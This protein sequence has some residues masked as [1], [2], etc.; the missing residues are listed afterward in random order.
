MQPERAFNWK[1]A[2]IYQIY[3]RSFQDS[4]GDGV[5]DIPGIIMR[6]DYIASL[7]VDAVWLNPIYASPNA[8]NGYD[9]SDYYSVMPEF[10]DLADFDELVSG[11]HERGLHLIMDLVVNH[12]SDEHH[13][14]KESRKSADNFYADFYHWWPAARGKPPHRWSFFSES[15]A[16]WTYVP[17]RDAWYL[18]YFGAKQPDLNWENPAVR[19]EVHRLMRFWLDRG[20]DGFRLD[21]IPFIAKDTSFPELPPGSTDE[22]FIAHYV[23]GPNLHQYLQELQRE[24]LSPYGAMSVGEAPGVSCGRAL[25]FVAR[26]R[27]EL[28]MFFHFDL[29]SI[30]RDPGNF[31]RRRREG[32]ALA[33]LRDIFLRWDYVFEND[34]WTAVYLGNHDFPRA[35]SRWTADDKDNWYRAATMLN[36]LL[37][38]IR[39]TP[40]LYYGDEIGMRNIRFQQI[41]E[42]RDGSSISR[43]RQVVARGGEPGEFL[44]ELAETSRDNARTPMQ[45]DA[46]EHAG[47][48]TSEP[49]ISVNPDHADWVSVAAQT[50]RE[51]SVLTFVRQLISYRRRSPALLRGSMVPVHV[52]DNAY[53]IYYRKAP[54]EEILVVLNFSIDRRPLPCVAEFASF[55]CVASNFPVPEPGFV[56]GQVLPGYAAF[57]LR[58]E[59]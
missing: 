53:F 1:E 11:L 41:H 2:V 27:G 30:D 38:T 34:G 24:V 12:T 46:S 31:F 22:D 15:G 13:W 19:V 4:N 43:Y 47:F 44:Q 58:R 9:I 10:G 52:D 14:F 57:L 50:S 40:F 55:T 5:G 32:W 37:L 18:H 54:R 36:T 20:V 51:D 23:N 33:E 56:A 16:A 42:Y 45:W 25:D 39:G 26:E 29:M 3:P 28:D 48:S 21:V 35:V 17:E 8:D 49:W 6:L 7:G 59:V